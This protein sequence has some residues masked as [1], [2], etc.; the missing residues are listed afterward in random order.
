MTAVQEL[1][2]SF[3]NLPD[4]EKHQAAVEILRWW[5]HA[6]SAPFADDEL[7]AAADE[8]FTRYDVDEGGA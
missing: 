4:D 5:Q 7:V 8:I 2:R 3:E 6:D 1:L